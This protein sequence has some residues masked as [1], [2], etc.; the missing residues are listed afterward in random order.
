[1][2]HAIPRG[3]DRRRPQPVQFLSENGQMSIGIPFGITSPD[4]T[5]QDL[6]TAWKEVSQVMRRGE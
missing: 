1:M 5:G 3:S 2:D 6:N 4:D